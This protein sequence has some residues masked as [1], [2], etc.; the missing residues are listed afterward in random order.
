M[1]VSWRE[2]VR[3]SSI[4]PTFPASRASCQSSG[5]EWNVTVI[6]RRILLSFR[7]EHSETD[8]E[9]LPALSRVNDFVDESELG[10]FVGVRELR[11]ILGDELRARL[12][13]VRGLVDGVLVNDV[14]RPVGAH[15]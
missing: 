7:R 4:A 11:S 14:H 8:G 3:R 15:H 2:L 1:Q 6:L 13:L 12:F 9:P 5:S 10:G